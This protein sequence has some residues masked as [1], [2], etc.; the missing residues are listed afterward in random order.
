MKREHN[1]NPSM[2]RVTRKTK[3]T[4]LLTALA[5]DTKICGLKNGTSIFI[6]SMRNY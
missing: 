6:Y 3:N 5:F 4:L 2:Y 1:P